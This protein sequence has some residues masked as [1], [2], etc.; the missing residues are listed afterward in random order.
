MI[1]SFFEKNAEDTAVEQV[2]VNLDEVTTVSV[3]MKDGPI[4]QVQQITFHCTD[5]AT[6][7]CQRCNMC[8]CVGRLL[9]DEAAV[10]VLNQLYRD[11]LEYVKRKN[12]ILPQA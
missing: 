2:F 8:S 11:W 4:L 5:G 10:N 7:L 12:V 9:T 1:L 3:R 6:V